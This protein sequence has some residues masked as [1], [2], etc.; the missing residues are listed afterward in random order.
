MPE[1]TKVTAEALKKAIHQIASLSDA[2]LAPLVT[3]GEA[4]SYGDGETIFYEGQSAKALY[5]LL[6]GRIRIHRKLSTGTQVDLATLEQGAIFGEVALLADSSRTA[7][8]AADGP[9]TVLRIPGDMLYADYRDGKP[10]ARTLLLAVSRLLAG[11]LEA[12]N[13]RVADMITQQSR[14]GDLDVFRKKM[15]QDWTL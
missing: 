1:F 6:E 15:F 10:Y 14:G 11:R 13:R 8:A 2:E 12:M 7:A 4:K 3:N 5:F 9:I